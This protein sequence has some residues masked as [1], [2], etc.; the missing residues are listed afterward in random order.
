MMNQ[1]EFNRPDGAGYGFLVDTVLALDPKNP[2]V[3]ARMLSALKSWRVLEPS[4]RRLAQS[5][6]KRVAASP[7][8]SRDV[9]DIA[10]RALGDEKD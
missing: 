7:A 1:K 5:A 10:T 8:L 6:L 2:Q 3:A 9:H 4:R